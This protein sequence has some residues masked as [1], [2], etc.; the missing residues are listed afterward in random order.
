MKPTRLECVVREEG[1]LGHNGEVR[2]EL[3]HDH[4]Y[5]HPEQ[6]FP[7]PLATFTLKTGEWDVRETNLKGI[8]AEASEAK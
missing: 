6:G 4:V 5:G 2:V 7:L 1:D 3:W 8:V